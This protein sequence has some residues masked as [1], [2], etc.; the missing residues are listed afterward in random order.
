MIFAGKCFKMILQQLSVSII[1]LLFDSAL[2]GKI[3]IKSH[4]QYAVRDFHFVST[5]RSCC[6]GAAAVLPCGTGEP[7]YRSWRR[8]WGGRQDQCDHQSQNTSCWKGSPKVIQS[9]PSAISRDIFNQVSLL[10]ALST[11]TSNIFRDGAS[12]TS[13]G[14]LFQCFTSLIVKKFVLKSSVSQPSFS[15]I[16]NPCPMAK[17]LL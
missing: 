7:G 5:G 17:G 14:S 2:P 10:R 16:N 1:S 8:W 4:R 12:I 3:N 11:L 6:L 15:L 9:N 13:V